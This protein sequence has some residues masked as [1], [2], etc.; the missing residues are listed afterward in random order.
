MKAL[1][2][3][4]GGEVSGLDLAAGWPPDVVQVTFPLHAGFSKAVQ[5]KDVGL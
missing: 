5:P 1:A 2:Q 4:P 3:E